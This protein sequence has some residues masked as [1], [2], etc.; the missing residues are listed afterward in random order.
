MSTGSNFEALKAQAIAA[1]NEYVHRTKYCTSGEIVPNSED[2]QTH[3]QIDII[4]LIVIE[5][6][7]IYEQ[8]R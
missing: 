7:V 3:L 8:N 6:S 5:S 4:D 2:F 1:R